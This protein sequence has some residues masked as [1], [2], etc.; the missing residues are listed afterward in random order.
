MRYIVVGTIAGILVASV[1][2]AQN[3]GSGCC[4]P[5]GPCAIAGS[6]VVELRGKV[7]G[8]QISPGAGMPFVTVKHGDELT[9]LYLGSIRYLMVQG[10]NPKVDEEIVAKAYKVNGNFIAASVT[11]PAQNKTVRLR[12]EDGRPVWRGGPRG[13]SNR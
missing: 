12:D 1:L 4:C 9:K 2:A 11:L 8:V 5:A 7:A 6:P 13:G 10:F 3:N